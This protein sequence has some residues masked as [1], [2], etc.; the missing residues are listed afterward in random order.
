MVV[1]TCGRSVGNRRFGYVHAYSGSEKITSGEKKCGTKCCER[2]FRKDHRRQGQ[3]VCE[4]SRHIHDSQRISLKRASTTQC[5]GAAVQRH[6]FCPHL[7]WMSRVLSQK[8]CQATSF[9]AEM[10]FVCLFSQPHRGNVE[11][12]R[13][14]PELEDSLMSEQARLFF[15]CLPCKSWRKDDHNTT[16]KLRNRRSSAE[17]ILW[18]APNFRSNSSRGSGLL[19]HKRVSARAF[20]VFPT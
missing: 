4:A 17:N 9:F 2:R 14:V 15:M 8:A 11:I 1:R 6:D 5:Q 18:L 13:H 20:R 7:G 19:N 16:E 12:R 10:R 3:V